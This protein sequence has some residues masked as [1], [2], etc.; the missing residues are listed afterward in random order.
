MGHEEKPKETTGPHTLCWIDK[1]KTDY[2]N[3]RAEKVPIS[4]RHFST[5]NEFRVPTVRYGFRMLAL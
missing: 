4:A 2:I 3:V 5:L 1:R